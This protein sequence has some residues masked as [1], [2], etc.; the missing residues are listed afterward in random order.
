MTTDSEILLVRLL[1]AYEAPWYPIRTRWERCSAIYYARRKAIP[2]GGGNVA[3]RQRICRQRDELT[4][5]GLIVGAALTA[6]GRRVARGLSWPYS[7]ADLKRVLGRIKKAIERGDYFVDAGLQLVPD[8]CIAPERGSDGVCEGTM[9]QRCLLPLL[10]DGVVISRGDPLGQTAYALSE[11]KMST[12]AIVKAT[13]DSSAEWREELAEAYDEESVRCLRRMA[14]DENR[15]SELGEVPICF[16]KLV[17]GKWW[18]ETK[19]R[20]LFR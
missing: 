3:E 2:V 8:D 16:D 6:E 14:G 15:Y 7:P 17:S 10:A 13:V 9:A 20:A 19:P 18:F 12:A 1:A 5:A 11:T 4:A